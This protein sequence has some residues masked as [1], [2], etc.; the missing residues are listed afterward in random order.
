MLWSCF[1]SHLTAAAEQGRWRPG[2]GKLRRRSGSRPARVHQRTCGQSHGDFSKG[3]DHNHARR[4]AGVDE[5]VMDSALDG[6]GVR[7]QG[8]GRVYFVGRLEFHVV[9]WPRPSTLGAAS[10]RSPSR[11]QSKNA[12]PDRP[13]A[14]HLNH[15]AQTRNAQQPCRNT[16]K[17]IP[18]SA[19]K[20]NLAGGSND[21]QLNA[22]TIA[23]RLGG[24]K[25]DIIRLRPTFY[26]APTTRPHGAWSE[27]L[28]RRPTRIRA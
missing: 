13:S 18:F 19:T 17:H 22:Q 5:T 9:K 25:A 26:S 28:R 16:M 10:S 20:H 7:R 12:R 11:F 23:Q 27:S 24:R 21:G 14:R 15:C 6:F 2:P 4:E 8:D 1:G 3:E